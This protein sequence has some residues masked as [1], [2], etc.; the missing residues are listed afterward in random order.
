MRYFPL[1]CI[2]INTMSQSPSAYNFRM[3][4]A[5]GFTVT[6]NYTLAISCN[7]YVELFFYLGKIE[8]G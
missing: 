3:N 5:V 2:W 6:L 7:I 8:Q 4:P 1:I